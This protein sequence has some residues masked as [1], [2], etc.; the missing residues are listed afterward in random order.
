MDIYRLA[1][2]LEDLVPEIVEL[3]GYLLVNRFG[4][5][6]AELNARTRSYKSMPEAQSWMNIVLLD[7]FICEVVGSE[8][9]SDDPSAVRLLSI[10]ERAWSHQVRA[11]YPAVSFRIERLVDDESGDLG[12]RLLSKT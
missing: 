7:G 4:Q 3:D 12:L 6:A 9:Q 10:F 2:W 5:S 8:W 11:L 1:Y